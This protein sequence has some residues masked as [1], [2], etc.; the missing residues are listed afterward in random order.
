MS[1]LRDLVAEE[2]SQP[3]DPRAADMAKAI[4]EKHSPASRAVIVCTRSSNA[5]TET[6]SPRSADDSA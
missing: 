4:A 2:L 6:G 5:N 3:V 1:S